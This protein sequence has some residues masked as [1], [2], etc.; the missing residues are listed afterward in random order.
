M[1]IFVAVGTQLAF[2]RLIEAMDTWVAD[3]PDAE[4]FAQT[5]PS[6]YVAKHM[7]TSPFIPPPVFET[8]SKEADLIVAHA[9]TGSIFT[10][11]ELKKPIII[12]PRRAK[13]GEHRNDH[14]LATAQR[15]EDRHG[16]NVAWN[17]QE[18]HRLLN[19]PTKLSR[20][21]AAFSHTATPELIAA[22][23]EFIHQPTP[24]RKRDRLRKWARAL[25]P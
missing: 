22:L 18:L 3:H 1:K 2:D 7:D 19:E 6:T 15:F 8:H 10:A 20:P 4:V 14:Q 11:L 25:R 5:G 21:D 23:R 9:G 13:F 16:I 12:M 24:L 17:E